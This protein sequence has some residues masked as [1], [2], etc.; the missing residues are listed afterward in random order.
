M[1]FTALAFLIFAALLRDWGSRHGAGIQ[2]LAC[3][4]PKLTGLTTFETVPGVWGLGSGCLASNA[5][6]TAHLLCDRGQG[7]SPQSLRSHIGEGG[8]TAGVVTLKAIRHRE[9]RRQEAICRRGLL[10]LRERDPQWISRPQTCGGNWRRP[11]G[12]WAVIISGMEQS[13]LA[14]PERGCTVYSGSEVKASACNAGDLGSIPGLGRYPG[15]GNGN[16]LQYSYLEN[17]MDAGAWWATVHGVTKSWTRLSNF[18][19]KLTSQL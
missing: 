5:G 4:T 2:T 8:K 18:T 10:H 9:C 7:T 6:S 1:R 11:P 15:E 14:V 13:E 16:P 19:L 12:E 17:P 3:V